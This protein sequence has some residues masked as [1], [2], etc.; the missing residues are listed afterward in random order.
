M[1]KWIIQDI[2]D[3]LMDIKGK[4]MKIISNGNVF[5]REIYADNIGYELPPLFRVTKG[6]PIGFKTSWI[7]IKDKE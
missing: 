6:F 2:P 7:D 1:D 5:Y 4:K 3:F